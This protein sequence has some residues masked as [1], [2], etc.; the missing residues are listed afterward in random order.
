MNLQSTLQINGFGTSEGVRKEWETRGRGR[1]TQ[2]PEFK[3]WFGKSKVI[4]KK[5]KPLLVYRGFNGPDKLATNREETKTAL[6]SYGSYFSSSPDVAKAYGTQVFPA[7]LKMEHPY[8]VDA[9]GEDYYH[10]PIPKEMSGKIVGDAATSDLVIQFAYKHGYD[11]AVI[12]NVFEPAASVANADDYIVF[13]PEQVRQAGDTRVVRSRS[14]G[15]FI[16]RDFAE[17]SK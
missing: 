8:I 11:G 9:K 1:V 17:A 6:G 14:S 4:D 12:R 13:R 7:Y 15:G 16:F 5:G 3:K 2:T 10:L